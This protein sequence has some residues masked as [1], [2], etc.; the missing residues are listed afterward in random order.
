MLNVFDQL[1]QNEALVDVT[2]ACDGLSLKAHKVVLSACS[3][4]FQSLFLDNPCQHPIVFLKD[5]RYSDLKALVDFMYKGEV[6]VSQEQLNAVLET[7]ESLKVKG[8]AE[9][10]P[11]GPQQG[12]T[13]DISYHI[14]KVIRNTASIGLNIT[15]APSKDSGGLLSSASPPPS[16]RPAITSSSSSSG[17]DQTKRCCSPPA[18][19]R[20]AKPRKRIPENAIPS[21]HEDSDALDLSTASPE[22][23]ETCMDLH[24]GSFDTTVGENRKTGVAI[25]LGTCSNNNNNGSSNNN[26]NALQSSL[27]HLDVEENVSPHEKVTDLF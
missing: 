12:R 18:K 13:G 8:L 15:E 4:Y 2:L 17:Q 5:V 27:L 7:A 16:P 21:D 22:L 9:M 26:S 3:P 25:H 11:E 19:R 6:N 24:D 10:T 20:K 23:L 1:F 14:S